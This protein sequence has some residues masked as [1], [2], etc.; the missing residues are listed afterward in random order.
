MEALR[1]DCFRAWPAGDARAIATIGN[2]QTADGLRLTTSQF[3]SEEGI[4]LTLW[5]LQRADLKP[6]DLELVV[7]NVLGDEGW[8]EF[9]T[10]V[11][12]AFPDQFPGVPP[13]AKNFAEERKML[14]GT[15]WAMAYVCPRGAGPTSWAALS[16]PKQTHLRR[17]LFLLGESLESGQVWDI[18]QA[19]AALRSLPGYAQTPLWLQAQKIMAGN[20]LYASLFIPDVKRLDLHALPASQKN[21]PIYLNVLRHLDLPQA[22]VLAAE[23][24]T[25]AIYTAEG[26]DWRYTIDTANALGWDKKRVQIRQPL[27]DATAAAR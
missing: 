10:L 25:L 13:D 17:R 9:Q 2:V 11:A 18:R 6:E 19:A 20:A 27:G 5:L 14:L 22:A 16:L 7:L 23:R 15:K 21:G 4:P 12:S 24:S 26:A 1:R 3:T 8:Q